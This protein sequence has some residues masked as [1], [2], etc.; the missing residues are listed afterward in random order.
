MKVKEI[1]SILPK[2]DLEKD[3]CE[4]YIVNF[5]NTKN[6]PNWRDEQIEIY[7]YKIGKQILKNNLLNSEIIQVASGR[8]LVGGEYDNTL[9]IY[10]RLEV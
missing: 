7:D 4:G 10:V 5:V 2:W 3:G 6:I 1:L 9:T 8:S